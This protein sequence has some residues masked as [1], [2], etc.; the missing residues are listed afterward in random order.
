MSAAV[1]ERLNRR[2]GLE[3]QRMGSDT[4]EVGLGGAA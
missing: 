4:P 3:V 2:V 1:A